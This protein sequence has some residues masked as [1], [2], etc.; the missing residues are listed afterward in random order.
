VIVL[1]GVTKRYG[2]AVALRSIDLDVAEGEALAV[3]GHNGSGKTTLLKLMAGLLRPTSGTVTIEGSRPRDVRARLGYVG[4]EPYLYP[5]LS[6]TENLTF[7]ARLYGVPPSR[8]PG[9][10]EQVGVG[11]KR[12]SLVHTL[13]RGERQRVSL[14]RALIHDPDILLA[15]EPF[16]GLDSAAAATV[17]ALLRREGRTIVIAAHDPGQAMSVCDRAVTLERGW[18]RDGAAGPSGAAGPPPGEGPATAPVRD[19]AGGGRP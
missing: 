15:D 4:H 10:L 6:A 5:Y 3:F 7:Y 11:H 1:R 16:S 18:I 14:A 2:A 13:S 17:P 19:R 9:L 8:G 12:D